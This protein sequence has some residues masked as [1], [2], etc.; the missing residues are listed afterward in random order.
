MSVRLN[1][2]TDSAECDRPV[3]RRGLPVALS[4][5]PTHHSPLTGLVDCWVAEAGEPA[6]S[7]TSGRPPLTP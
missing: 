4:S 2:Q 3:S 5:I 1:V 6:A 7:L